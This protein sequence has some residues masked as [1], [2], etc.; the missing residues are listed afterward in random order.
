VTR[1]PWT[2]R[3]CRALVAAASWLVPGAQRAAWK[4][5]WEAEVLHRWQRL[6]GAGGARW[7]E[8]IDIL[9]RVSGALPD[10]AWMRRQ[11]TAD[12]E[13]V[14]DLR[15]AWRLMRRQRASALAMV[16]VLGLGIGSTTAVFALVDALL[17]RPVPYAEPDRLMLL[18]ETNPRA[19]VAENEVSPGNFLDWTERSR[20]YESMAAAI[21]FSY[22]YTGGTVPEVFFAVRV[23][24]GFFR[25]LGV[26]PLLGR[27]FVPEEHRHG[28]E[29]VVL[30]DHGFWKRRFGADPRIV[31][32]TLPLEGQPYTV[33]GV[34]PPD[35]E[36]GLLPTS[37]PRGVWTPHVIEDYER[38]TRGTTWWAA[39]ARLRPGVTR[40]AAQAEMDAIA[41]ALEREYPRTNREVRVRLVPFFEHLTGSVR[42]PL[43]L[44]AWAAGLVL[45][46]AAANV[47]GLL[48]ARGAEREREL[49]V[50][51]ALGAGRA[52]IVRQLVSESLLLGALGGALGVMLARWAAGALVALSPVDVPRLGTVQVDGR[53]LLFAAAASLVTTILCGTVAALVASR[54]AGRGSL[55]ETG[56]AV[57]GGLRRQGLRR[58]LVV[59]QVAAALVLLFGAGLLGRSFLRLLRTDP[60]FRTEGAVALQVF[61][62]D[63]NPTPA[64]Q[65]AFLRE[66]LARIEALPGVLAAG[67][68]SRMP[69]I[70]ANIGIRSPLTIEGRPAVP[71]EEASAY[72]T[73]ATRRYFETMGIPLRAGRWFADSDR[74]DAASVAL[75]NESLARRQWP[76]A[77][78]VGSRISVRW[79]GK[80]IT[81]EVV[82]VVGSARHRRLDGEPDAELFLSSDQLPYGSMTYVVRAQSGGTALIGPVQRAIWSVDPLQAFY[83]TATLDE[84][85]AKSLSARRFL[86]LV[87]AAFAGVALAL[88]ATGLYGL[89]SFLATRR[90]QEIGVRVALGARGA[91]IF[92][93]VVGEGMTLA[94]GGLAVGLIGCLWAA[95]LLEGALFG[96]SAVDPATA[97]AVL[98][99]LAGAAFLACAL[100]ALRA[101]RVDPVTALRGE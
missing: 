54:P 2:L 48:L 62:W 77:D 61:M 6:N 40:D 63:R 83:R 98:S 78:P 72:L 66:T 92:R 28:R 34:L 13:V 84:L 95:R 35:F 80:P 71:G 42:R 21:P 45:L 37:G 7:P 91:D 5:E 18:G 47:V 96:V 57:P 39:I 11:F 27:D 65:A 15:H 8:R 70:E 29:N 64:K 58:S 26:A 9:R 74:L 59:G 93:L 22:D 31:G 76:G 1:E 75:V 30:L 46:L 43:L 60:G 50:R 99:L 3:A 85:V 73:I 17:L 38:R 49:A 44:L 20:S 23:T 68:V 86:L 82:G 53:A 81:A 89:M 67:A 41:A 56:R 100:P 51:A 79:H 55:R 14:Q 36:P 90:T 88:A 101:L 10:A 52:R 12:A 16:A 69:F 24:E 94:A 32:S 4:Q 87:L 25:T 19:A 33:V 97:V